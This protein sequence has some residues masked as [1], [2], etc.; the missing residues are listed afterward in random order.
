MYFF[1][2][3]IESMNET[4]FIIS[5]VNNFKF[6]KFE[7]N[8]IKFRKINLKIFQNIDPFYFRKM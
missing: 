6:P 2:S 3:Q 4:L 1:G 8:L 5:A 7:R